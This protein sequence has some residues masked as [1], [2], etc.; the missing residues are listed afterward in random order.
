[1]TNDYTTHV[2]ALLRSS[3]KESFLPLWL[4][5]RHQHYPG[6]YHLEAFLDCALLLRNQIPAELWWLLVLRF[7]E[8]RLDISKGTNAQADALYDFSSVMRR[9]AQPLGL[10]AEE[11]LD[12][13]RQ[14]GQICVSEEKWQFDRLM[15][16]FYWLLRDKD[17]LLARQRDFLESGEIDSLYCVNFQPCDIPATPPD[18]VLP[19]TAI[20]PSAR[21][22][23]WQI[24]AWESSI[25]WDGTSLELHA[26]FCFD[27][28]HLDGAGL[29]SLLASCDLSQLGDEAGA[30]GGASLQVELD[31]RLENPGRVL[32]GISALEHDPDT[33]DWT[34]RSAY[35][36][37]ERPVDTPPGQQIH[38]ELDADDPAW[39][40]M[41]RNP[42]SAPYR[43]YCDIDIDTMLSSPHGL[44]LMLM[45]DDDP[46]PKQ[47]SVI[48]GDII[49]HPSAS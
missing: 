25:G 42:Y 39:Q 37:L 27:T 31:Q 30:L 19:G 15:N 32:L 33:G 1:M 35:S 38:L 4:E 44:F 34:G 6:Y 41:G 21:P 47:G 28:N 46:E 20:G 3:G 16:E 22:D 36:M 49:L 2:R 40:S 14:L 9:L 17:T 23:L 12:A 48:I 5:F 26:P 18:E 45:Q 8:I 29:F 10:E 11:I 13:S 43:K 24:C 7:C